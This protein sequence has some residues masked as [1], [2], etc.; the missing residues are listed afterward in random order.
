VFDGGYS[1]GIVDSIFNVD[2]HRFFY[3]E[4]YLWNLYSLMPGKQMTFQNYLTYY[5]TDGVQWKMALAPTLPAEIYAN[6]GYAYPVVI[7]LFGAISKIILD[8]LR[9]N[10]LSRGKDVFILSLIFYYLYSLFLIRTIEGGLGAYLIMLLGGVIF[11][12]NFILMKF[13]RNSFS[14]AQ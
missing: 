11:L 12:F 8:Y 10:I 14:Y 7:F 2:K 6:F 3:G 1:I 9:G 4:T 5:V 13:V